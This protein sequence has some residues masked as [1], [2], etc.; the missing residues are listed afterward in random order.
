MTVKRWSLAAV[1][2]AT[3]MLLTGCHT[4]HDVELRYVWDT[5]AAEELTN[6]RDVTET[7]CGAQFDCVEAWQADQGLFL[8]FASKQDADAARIEDDVQIRDI[9]IIRWKQDIPSED[10]EYVEYMLR[11]AGTSE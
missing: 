5:E 4:A 7:V 3:A 2:I 1:L 6:Q 9:F 11:N 10:K 8:K